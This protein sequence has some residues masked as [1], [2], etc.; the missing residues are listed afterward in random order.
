MVSVAKCLVLVILII[1]DLIAYDGQTILDENPGEIL[2]DSYV[3]HL[4]LVVIL[5]PACVLEAAF[6]WGAIIIIRQTNEIMTSS[7][8]PLVLKQGM[9]IIEVD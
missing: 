2:W 7:W 9:T 4:T 3:S 5:V 6:V 1:I 8:A